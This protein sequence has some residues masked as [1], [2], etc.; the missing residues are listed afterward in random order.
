MSRGR[1]LAFLSRPEATGTA[2]SL[3]PDQQEVE[4]E[5][6]GREGDAEEEEVAVA[7]V[8]TI[9]EEV[10]SMSLR[11]FLFSLLLDSKGQQ[12]YIFMTLLTTEFLYTRLVRL[13]GTTEKMEKTEETEAA[14]ADV[15]SQLLRFVDASFSWLG[16]G[17][18]QLHSLGFTVPRGRLT[19]VLGQSGAGKTS[20]LAA[21]TKEMVQTGGRRELDSAEQFSKYA[22]L[23]QHPWLLNASVKD[24]ILFGRPYKEKRYLKTVAAC[25]LQPDLEMLP[26]GADTEVGERGVLL[27]GGQRQ[28]ICLARCLYRF[29]TDYSVLVCIVPAAPPPPSCWTAPSRRWTRGW[30]PPAW[31][32]R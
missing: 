1:L 8:E 17:S 24:N 14:D 32:G 28:R 12:K 23:S 11:L 7:D 27:S 29:S 13:Q 16:G 20:L 30:G 25:Q 6:L 4:D 18:D 21:I 19:I 10:I 2:V 22:V 3:E 5:K 31:P 26:D 15:A 9:T